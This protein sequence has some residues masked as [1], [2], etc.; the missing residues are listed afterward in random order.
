MDSLSI[1]EDLFTGVACSFTAFK[2]AEVLKDSEE[3]FWLHNLLFIDCLEEHFKLS[4][5]TLIISY[6]IVKFNSQHLIPVALVPLLSEFEV[7]SC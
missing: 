3:C 1:G 5:S 4:C 6:L 7:N 2:E